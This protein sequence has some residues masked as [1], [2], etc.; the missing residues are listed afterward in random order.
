MN[1]GCIPTKT[2]LYSAKIYD[3]AVHGDKYGVKAENVSFD[4][5]KVMARK[6]KVVKKNLPNFSISF[7]QH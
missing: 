2:L 3:S 6:E 5:K 4:F 7:Y 1:E